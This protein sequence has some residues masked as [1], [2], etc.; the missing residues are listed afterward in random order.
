MADA[1]KVEKKPEKKATPSKKLPAVPESVLKRRKRRLEAKATILRNNLKKK[2][3]AIKT[4]KEIFKRAEKYVKEYRR[5]ERDEIRLARQARNRKNY[6]ISAEPRLA[7]VIRIRGINQVAP[8]VRKVL[9]LFR[10]RQINNGIFLKLNK[11]TL[12]MLRICEPYVTWGY[13]NLKSVRE[14]V[15]KRGFA[16]I[17]GQR[18]P[19]TSNSIIEGKLGKMNIICMEDLIHEVFTVGKNF[20]YASNFL[21]PFKLNTPTGGWRKKT[22]HYVEGGDFGN[23][24]DKI[25]ELLR[26]MV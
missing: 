10:L 2:A 22:N 18:I 4:R 5:R 15:Y 13:P 17:N 6:Y 21:W 1:A 19:I 8:K 14:L 9:Q 26:R 20:K 25:N 12:N 11:A 7:F 16:K 24:E 3:A 23:R